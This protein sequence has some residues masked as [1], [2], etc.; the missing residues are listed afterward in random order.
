MSSFPIFPLFVSISRCCS[1][2]VGNRKD[3]SLKK[4]RYLGHAR[5]FS[6]RWRAFLKSP[7][8]FQENSL[9][10]SWMR[11]G[12]LKIL[13]WRFWKFVKAGKVSFFKTGEKG[14]VGYV[15]VSLYTRKFAFQPF[16][17]F[18][19]GQSNEWFSSHFFER[20]TGWRVR[21]SCYMYMRIRVRVIKLRCS[22]KRPWKAAE[23]PCWRTHLQIS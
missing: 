8:C 16:T 14:F 21:E 13:P 17:P 23:K 12:A 18:T 19:L 11:L 6:K 4:N 15:F 9:T 22:I 7:W 20:W 1:W 3:N 10:N 2:K 5:T